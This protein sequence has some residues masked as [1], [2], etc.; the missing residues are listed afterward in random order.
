MDDSPQ[1]KRTHSDT[2]KSRK[3]VKGMKQGADVVSLQVIEE[4]LTTNQ[5]KAQTPASPRLFDED[6]SRQF[7]EDD[8]IIRDFD[9]H[10]PL[11]VSKSISVHLALPP[12]AVADIIRGHDPQES[13]D[14]VVSEQLSSFRMTPEEMGSMTGDTFIRWIMKAGGALPFAEHLR[15]LFP[16][17]DIAL[18]LDIAGQYMTQKK[19]ALFLFQTVPADEDFEENWLKLKKF[20]IASHAKADFVNMSDVKDSAKGGQGGGKPSVADGSDMRSHKTARL[21][22]VMVNGK[23]VDFKK[24]GMFYKY[25]VAAGG[26]KSIDPTIDSLGTYG[27]IPTIRKRLIEK[28]DKAGAGKWDEIVVQV[29]TG[30]RSDDNENVLSSH[31]ADFVSGV[32]KDDENRAAIMQ[33]LQIM[34][35]IL[36]FSNEVYKFL[37][38]MSQ[39]LDITNNKVYTCAFAPTISVTFTRKGAKGSKALFE[40]SMQREMPAIATLCTF[41]ERKFLYGPRSGEFRNQCLNYLAFEWGVVPEDIVVTVKW[42]PNKSAGYIPLQSFARAKQALTE[43]ERQEYLR[44]RFFTNKGETFNNVFSMLAIPMNNFYCSFPSADK[45]SEINQVTVSSVLPIVVN[46]SLLGRASVAGD[47]GCS[48]DASSMP[49]ISFLSN[50]PAPASLGAILGSSASWGMPD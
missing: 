17:S 44:P 34:D 3:R 6:E 27:V 36:R 47:I 20:M 42:T 31:L 39:A 11:D 12:P 35:T 25:S 46:E 37:F 32:A 15:N 1:L 43:R 16:A 33:Q 23:S 49:S 30:L 4:N 29:K 9:E 45:K 22:A 5:E 8:A 18:F 26:V 19:D 40:R 41:I 10:A 14:S 50:A 48:M 24:T 2:E 13:F 38:P 7:D 28:V 21:R